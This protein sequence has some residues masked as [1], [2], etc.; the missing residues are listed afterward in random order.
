MLTQGRAQNNP[1]DED[2]FLK[3][4]AMF[5]GD[6][7][8]KEMLKGYE[9][10]ASWIHYVQSTQEYRRIFVYIRP[11]DLSSFLS[12][13]FR[14]PT[15]L[16]RITMRLSSGALLLLYWATASSAILVATPLTINDQVTP[17]RWA[18]YDLTQVE[19]GGNHTDVEASVV[20]RKSMKDVRVCERVLTAAAACVVLINGL[21]A[22]AGA[23]GGLIRGLADQHS[24]GKSYG[25]L[26]GISWVYYASGS[27]CDTT[28]ES[29][30]IAGAIKQHLSTVDHSTLCTTDCLDLTHSGTWNGWLLVGPTNNFNTDLYCGP[31]LSFSTCKSGGKNDIR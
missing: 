26:D 22:I 10:I 12:L 17:D 15:S 7:V 13:Y 31:S 25:S 2:R 16:A 1:V 14:N 28:A 20:P 23:L 27:N 5:V 29:L 4:Q 21:S 30:T 19:E 24:C 6:L 8:G 18:K 3:N 9:G 11:N